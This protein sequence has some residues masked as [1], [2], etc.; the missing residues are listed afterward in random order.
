[1]M[2][3]GNVAMALDSEVLITLPCGDA[4]TPRTIFA[5]GAMAWAHSTSR[6]VSTVQLIS[7]CGMFLGLNV[8]QPVGQ[9]IVKDGG[10]G[11]PK[12]LSK[13]ARSFVIVGLPKA[14]TMRMVWPLPSGL[15]GEC[16]AGRMKLGEQQIISFTLDL[17]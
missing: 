13:T 12:V 3:P 16:E 17:V 5:P 10:A 15:D 4:A 9:R 2:L 7:A 8:G 1:M 6:L 14:S 11:I